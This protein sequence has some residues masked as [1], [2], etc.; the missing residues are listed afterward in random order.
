DSASRPYSLRASVAFLQTS[1]GQAPDR[2]R[3][4]V[5][6]FHDKQLEEYR[7]GFGP[8]DSD[9]IYHGVVWPLLG[10]EDENT[11][12]VGEIET[13]LR[14]SG[15]TEIVL[16]N[17]QFPFEFCDDCGAPL[18]PNIEGD[19]VHAEMPEQHDSPSQTLH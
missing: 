10:A 1:L 5:A 3:A 19:T 16:L 17:Q 8:R 9:L 6:G 4:I 7:V 14:E 13:V 18:F 11:D 12:I 2:M 15:I